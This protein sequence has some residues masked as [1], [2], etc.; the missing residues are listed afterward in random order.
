MKPYNLIKVRKICAAGLVL[1]A[2]PSMLAAKHLGNGR[3]AQKT[4]DRKK[5]VLARHSSEG[6]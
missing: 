3:G 2:W 6:M 4:E 1:F 5:D